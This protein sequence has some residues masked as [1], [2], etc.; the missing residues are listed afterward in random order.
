MDQDESSNITSDHFLLNPDLWKY[1]RVT[2]GEPHVSISGPA[3]PVTAASLHLKAQEA[4]R[5]DSWHFGAPPDITDDPRHPAFKVVDERSLV[6]SEQSRAIEAFHKVSALHSKVANL[7]DIPLFQS[8]DGPLRKFTFQNGTVASWYMQRLNPPPREK[9]LPAI[10]QAIT[11]HVCQIYA[12]ASPRK[13][14][15]SAA[16]PANTNGGWPTFVT[17]P[18]AKVVGAMS[19]SGSF[20]ATLECALRIAAGLGIDPSTALGNGLTG[21]SGPLY[22]AQPLLR[23]TGAGWESIG[24]WQGYSQRNRVVQMACAAVNRGLRPIFD[25]WHEAR[26]HIPGLWHSAGRDAHFIRGRRYMYE[27]DIS[28]FDINVS[29]PLQTLIAWHTSRA[30]PQISAAVNFWL[31]AERLPLIC[32]SWARNFNLCTVMFSDGGTHSGLKPTAEIGTLISVI[33]CLYACYLCGLNP[34]EWPYMPKASLLVQGDDVL[35]ATDVPLDPDVWQAAYAD[36]GLTSALIQGDLFLSR[37]MS[38]P[39]RTLPNAGRIIQQT[40]SNEHEPKGTPEEVDGLLILGFIAR[41]EQCEHL[42]AELSVEAATI[43]RLA[44]WT[45][46]YSAARKGRGLDGM[47]HSLMNDPAAQRAIVTSLNHARNQDWLTRQ[48]RD[49]EHSPAAAYLAHYLETKRP[50]LLRN[51]LGLDTIT[52]AYIDEMCLLPQEDRI[53]RAIEWGRLLMSDRKAARQRWL[54]LV[55]SAIDYLSDRAA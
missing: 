43:C 46:R 30:R 8:E 7:T 40:L 17:E 52:A 6:V 9:P 48:Y 2:A 11:R 33:A 22:K 49:R 21:R 34:F 45:E 16:D 55:P 15:T 20:E 23:F 24:E 54:A 1:H 19:Y 5:P 37:H 12:L 10:I 25:Y 4:H 14:I 18:L 27:S 41:T 36:L 13:A 53:Q 26:K 39:G 44:E 42:P 38:Q 29:R 3:V 51:P 50:E 35:A 32:P 31:H 47:R 28:G